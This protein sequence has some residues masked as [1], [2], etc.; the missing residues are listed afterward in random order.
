MKEYIVEWKPA[1][2]MNRQVRK[3]RISNESV[4]AVLAR[5]EHIEPGCKV[6]RI[7]ELIY[8]WRN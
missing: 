1:W 2:D 8:D 3:W 6:F 7:Y 4:E 5:M